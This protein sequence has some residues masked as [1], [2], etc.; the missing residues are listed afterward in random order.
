MFKMI[1]LSALVVGASGVLTLTTSTSAKAW[2][3]SA[4]G[5]TGASSWGRSGDLGEA[6]GIALRECSVRT[7]RGETCYIMYCNGNG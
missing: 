4:R 7:Q 3:C 1:L 5:T 2:Y 6:K